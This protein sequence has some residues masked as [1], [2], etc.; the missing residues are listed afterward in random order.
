M[1]WAV[2]LRIYA[3]TAKFPA[4]HLCA[5]LADLDARERQQYDG[6]AAGLSHTVEESVNRN[7]AKTVRDEMKKTLVPRESLFSAEQV[8]SIL[9]VASNS[10]WI[11]LVDLAKSD[12]HT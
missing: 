10:H 5:A 1:T 7:L 3:F 11:I 9:Q 6:L 2:K 12:T 8:T 4:E